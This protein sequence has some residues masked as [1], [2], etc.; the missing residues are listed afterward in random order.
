MGRSLK[1]PDEHLMKKLKL[2]QMTKRKVIKTG[3]VVQ[4]SSPASSDTLISVYD[5]RKHVPVYI[6]DMVGRGWWICTNS[7]FTKSRGRRQEDT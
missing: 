5:G 6:Q 3:H 1:G 2:K 7:Y 4:R